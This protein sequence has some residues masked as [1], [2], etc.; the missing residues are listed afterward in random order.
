MDRFNP[1][2]ISFRTL[3]A[4]A[5]RRTHQF[6]CIES[7][8]LLAAISAIER[9]RAQWSGNHRPCRLAIV[10]MLV[11]VASISQARPTAIMGCRVD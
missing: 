9:N 2:V 11:A 10:S 1:M 8:S 6:A 5:N 7:W 4:H 3:V